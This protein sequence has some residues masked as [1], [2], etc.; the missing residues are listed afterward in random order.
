M[1]IPHVLPVLL[2]G[3]DEKLPAP[4]GLLS[5]VLHA[6]SGVRYL[7]LIGLIAAV[8]L[9]FNAMRK[10]QAWD[11]SPKRLGR[12]TMILADIQLLMGIFLWVYFIYF[13]AV[14][15]AVMM[16]IAIVLIHIGYIRAK[17]APSVRQANKSQFLF[18]LIAL[19]MI[20]VAIPWPFY[21]HMGRGWF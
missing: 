20:L 16:F 5:A 17:K 21:G 14:E 12:L 6:H 2:F 13:M 9:A 10:D 1:E 19:I 4:Y 11:G 7:I 15:H 8:F 3:S 18:Y